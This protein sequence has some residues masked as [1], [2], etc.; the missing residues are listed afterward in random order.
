MNY[1]EALLEIK[2]VVMLNHAS[3]NKNTRKVNPTFVAKYKPSILV[4]YCYDDLLIAI[5][6]IKEDKWSIFTYLG[7][8]IW[9][10]NRLSITCYPPSYL[11]SF[12]GRK[13]CVITQ[14]S[15]YFKR[16]VK[17]SSCMII[18]TINVNTNLWSKYTRNDSPYKISNNHF[19]NRHIKYV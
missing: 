4:W 17:L 8:M 18:C 9:N 5:T 10:E 14:K 11:F 7:C 3:I 19:R 13:I 6:N 2:S 12:L 1:V 16:D 15:V